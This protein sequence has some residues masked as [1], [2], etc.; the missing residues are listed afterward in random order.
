MSVIRMMLSDELE[1]REKKVKG[2]QCA[3][4][5]QWFEHAIVSKEYTDICASD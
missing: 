4:S 5:P 1:T 2:Y 3:L